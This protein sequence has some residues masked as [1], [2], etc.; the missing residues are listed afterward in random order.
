VS[1][2]ERLPDMKHVVEGRETQRGE[3][4]LGTKYVREREKEK[5]GKGQRCCSC[6]PPSD[7]LCSSNHNDRRRASEGESER[8]KEMEGGQKEREK[9]AQ[10]KLFCQRGERRRR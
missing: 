4:E 1:E 8:V 9:A 3:S 10:M 5:E 2:K 7:L 6:S